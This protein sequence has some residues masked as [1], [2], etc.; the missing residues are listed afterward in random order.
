MSIII[1][2]HSSRKVFT[3]KIENT[4]TIHDLKI[5]LESHTHINEC[6]QMLRKYNNSDNIW[7]ENDIKLMDYKIKHK[8]I[9]ELFEREFDYN[10]EIKSFKRVLNNI[11][12]KEYSLPTSLNNIVINYVFGDSTAYIKIKYYNH[13]YSNLNKPPPMFKVYLYEKGYLL[14]QKLKNQYKVDSQ[15]IMNGDCKRLILKKTLYEQP[16]FYGNNDI[17][18][19]YSIRRDIPDYDH[20]YFNSIWL[21]SAIKFDIQRCLKK[22]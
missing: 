17:I 22:L 21:D 5:G 6:D 11:K 18:K 20:V 19:I 7:L 16:K 14:L 2:N 12:Y 4:L 13:L 9:I 1:V 10:K 3:Y 15:W 8:S